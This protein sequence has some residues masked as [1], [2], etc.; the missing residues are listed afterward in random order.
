[1]CVKLTFKTGHILCAVVSLHRREDFGRVVSQSP[2]LSIAEE[3]ADDCNIGRLAGWKNSVRTWN[4]SNR[5]CT[6]TWSCPET[7]KNTFSVLL[8]DN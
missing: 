7:V 3:P 8:N 4:N 5:K 2:G 1:M 6:M